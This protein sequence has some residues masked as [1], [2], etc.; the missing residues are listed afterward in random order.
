MRIQDAL[1]QKF[2]DSGRI[3]DGSPPTGLD[4]FLDAL[5]DKAADIEDGEFDHWTV[6]KWN[7][8]SLAS[9]KNKGEWWTRF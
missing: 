7:L 3:K 2:P 6:A 1:L 4:I 9:A 5:L 8:G